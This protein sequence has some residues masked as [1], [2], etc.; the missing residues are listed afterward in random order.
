MKTLFEL[1]ADCDDAFLGLQEAERAG[2]GVDTAEALYNAAEDAMRRHPDFHTL[3]QPDA[4][5]KP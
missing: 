2:M 1:L 4:A 3:T 5:N